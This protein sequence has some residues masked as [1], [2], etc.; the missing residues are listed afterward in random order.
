MVF[1]GSHQLTN[2]AIGSIAQIFSLSAV[3]KRTSG[4]S[5]ACILCTIS[6]NSDLLFHGANTAAII[7]NGSGFSDET[8]V[9][10]GSCHYFEANGNATSTVFMIDGTPHTEA[11]G[12]GGIG[13]N[14]EV[15]GSGGTG[16]SFPL[17]GTI[18]EVIIYASDQSSLFA[19]LS[20]NQSTYGGC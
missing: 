13:D 5:T 17:T 1:G 19:S 8:G 18:R 15:G 2:A 20:S 4:T 10:D 3:A 11:Q 16:G 7:W 12:S 14:Y 9:A 6:T